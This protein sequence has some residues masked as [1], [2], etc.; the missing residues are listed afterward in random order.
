MLNERRE[1][2]M[3]RSFHFL[4]AA[5]G[6]VMALELNRASAADWPM[7]R[8]NAGR[9][10][11]TVE[12]LPEN[13]A[14]AWVRQ[15]PKISPAFHSVRLQ[16]DA[17]YE[18]VAARGKLLIASS[19][20]DSVTAYD[21][22]T[23]RKIWVYNT[24]G[25]IRFAP[26]IWNDS[27]CFGSDDGC[28]YCVDLA[29][30]TLRWKHR[31]V[32]SDRRLLGNRRL[33]SVWPIRGGPVVADGKV[34]FAA[35]VWPFEGV[36]VCAMD[37]AT[38]KLAWRNER[39]GYIFGQQPHDTK[40]IGGLAPQGYLI[41]NGDELIVP[42][43]TAYPARLNRET[44]ELIEFEL[45]A[46]GGLPGGWFASLDAETSRAIRRGKLTFD[47]VV[48]SQLHEDKVRMGKGSPGISRMIRAGDQTLKF[49]APLDDVEGTIHS[50]I[51]ADE[52]LFVS[53]RSGK[54]YCFR[55]AIPGKP[56]DVKIWKNTILPLSATP[57]MLAKAESL[58]KEAGGTHGV[59]VVAGLQDG[60]LT[61]ALTLKSSYHVI[62][63]D[64]DSGRV[65][66]LRNEL[67]QAGVYGTRVAVIQADP[68]S[69]SL[70]PYLANLITT[71]TPDRMADSWGELLPSL[72]P[73]GGVAALDVW[74]GV[75]IA[76][77]DKLKTL[78]PGSFELTAQKGNAQIR[79]VGALPGS[80]QYQGGYEHCEDTLVRFPLGVLWFDDTLS[81]FKRSPQPQ[82][83]DGVMVSR[84]KDW[85]APRVKG[86]WSIDYPLRAAVLSDMYTGRILH[87]SEAPT[88][89]KKL[90]DVGRSTPQPSYYH[91]P[92][93]KTYLS[94]DPPLAG[95]RVNPL[96]GL[97]EPRVFP[98]TYGCDG[99]VDYGLFY[100]LRSGTAA[101]YDKTLESG[102]VFISGP[103][104]GCSNSIIPSGGLLNVPYFYE[105][106]TCSYPLPSGLAMVAMPETYEQWASWGADPIAPDS[107]QRIGL[108]FG[109][110]GDRKTRDGT[111]WLDYPSVGGPS[112]KIRVE[113][114]PANPTF[115]Y[116]HSLWTK[117]GAGWPWV[118]A[119][120]VEGLRELTLR[121]LKPGSYTVRLH[122]AETEGTL[123]GARRQNIY[124]Q[125]KKVLNDLDILTEA[126]R[127]LTGIVRQ[128]DGVK[129][130]GSLTLKL[131]A[132]AGETLISGIELIRN[133]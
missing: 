32:P 36:F 12:S 72:R 90:P 37:I 79:R 101:F 54:I 20:N 99:G 82:F 23:G 94:P 3:N 92:H 46:P 22:A 38:G 9:T 121:D 47:D 27:V 80:A 133:P 105:G 24:D 45:P 107:I 103:R 115:H 71:E 124:F 15:L 59:A 51:V 52:R 85:Q 95:E 88:L 83:M 93:Q 126:K 53:T 55:E 120:A 130:E 63:I 6:L 31:V 119:S 81:H 2:N 100:T 67:K 131:D 62:A 19:R 11:A 33:I 8:Q 77:A 102:T 111:L 65:E 98:K 69:I 128:F 78:N 34:Y 39:L 97:K 60:A 104:S 114:S 13:L 56:S 89:R 28:F 86:D 50:M 106:C 57:S 75:G 68:R 14:L 26:A 129:I 30:G 21:A 91:A 113:T 7:W 70:P 132:P 58:I 118:G 41:V 29:D 112:P 48:N 17:G 16:F 64:D 74:P 96:T 35:G 117:S 87:K 73:Y 110:P 66:R 18:P 44:G 43:S 125:G 42:C 84:P 1:K 10:G 76:T 5:T 127:P 4:V 108:N 61:K 116:R 49:D 109:A 122:F 123:P 40:A 25:P